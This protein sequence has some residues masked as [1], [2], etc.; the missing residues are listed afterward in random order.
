M[1]TVVGSGAVDSVAPTRMAPTLEI[2]S[3]PG[4]RRGQYYL[5][6][7]GESLTNMGQQRLNVTTDEGEGR[8]VTFQVAEVNN[9]LT[10]VAKIRDQGNRVVFGAQGGYILNVKTGKITQFQRESGVYT[11]NL[12]LEAGGASS[13]GRP[14]Q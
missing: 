10:S 2:Q 8:S 1:K 12:W 14:G 3:P 11:L 6:E 9:P 4:C 5:S 7:P 13:F